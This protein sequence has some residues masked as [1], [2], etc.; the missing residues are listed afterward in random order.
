VTEEREDDPD[1]LR[2]MSENLLGNAERCYRLA[3][4]TTDFKV[5]ERLVEL[6]R[7]FELEA[8]HA[9]TRARR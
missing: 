8:E 5:R 4:G 2:A 3:R 7:E 9:K 6:A 1:V